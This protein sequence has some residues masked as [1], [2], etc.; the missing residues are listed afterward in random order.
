MDSNPGAKFFANQVFPSQP[1]W[2]FSKTHPSQRANPLHVIDPLVIQFYTN[3]L[4]CY[5]ICYD[6]KERFN[7]SSKPLESS[8]VV[9][10]IAS[11]VISFGTKGKVPQ[12][13]IKGK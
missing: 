13:L 12:I 11:Q 1:L 3:A 8:K 10:W 5:L 6:L 2:N 9:R 7:T 4:L